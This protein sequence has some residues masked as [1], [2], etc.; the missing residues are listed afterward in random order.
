MHEPE[1]LVIDDEQEMLT[2]YEKIL[3]KEG[4]PER[5][6]RICE[7][8]IGI[9]IRKQDIEEQSLPLPL[10]DYIPEKKEE[11][12]IAYADN[13]V[14]G[15]RIMD[16]EYVIERFRKELGDEFAKRV[17]KFHEEIH[18]MRKKSRKDS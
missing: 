14:K 15:N 8:H 1:I 7:T 5:F 3:K 4:W 10:K 17:E 11:K 9:G 12:I 2:S 13:L 16:E 18:E 6:Q